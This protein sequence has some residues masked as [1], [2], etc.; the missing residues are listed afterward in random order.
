MIYYGTDGAHSDSIGR[1]DL[2]KMTIYMARVCISICTS[3]TTEL[4]YVILPSSR[5]HNRYHVIPRLGIS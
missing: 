2:L 1:C 3:R 5:P 4:S